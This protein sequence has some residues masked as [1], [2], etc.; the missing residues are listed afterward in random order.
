MMM[1]DNLV[2]KYNDKSFLNERE[3]VLKLVVN[4]TLKRSKYVIGK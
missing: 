2:K 4:N 3:C 1:V